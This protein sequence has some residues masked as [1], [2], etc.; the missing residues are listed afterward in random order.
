MRRFTAVETRRALVF[1]LVL[2]MS[3]FV[4][5]GVRTT[6]STS[7]SAA[8]ALRPGNTT[9]PSGSGAASQDEYGGQ[10][11]THHH[12]GQAT[13][14]GKKEELTSLKERAVAG[15]RLPDCGHACGPCAPCKR[16]MVSF[17]CLHDAESCPLAYRCM[18]RGK[19]FR[20]PTF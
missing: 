12:Q 20:V 6:P 4:T 18:C 2:V 15:S 14:E 19:F 8:D 5:H 3:S 10:A 16:V 17:R 11:P 9:T 7:G 13:Q 1:A